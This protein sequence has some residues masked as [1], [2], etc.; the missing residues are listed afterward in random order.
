[1]R[2]RLN[3]G[4]KK[5]KRA[6]PK[7]AINEKAASKSYAIA[8]KIRKPKK[9][10]KTKKGWKPKRNWKPRK[11]K[12]PKDTG[13]SVPFYESSEW[14]ELRYEALKLHGRRCLCCG[15]KAPDVVIHVDHIKPRSI[16]PDLE[17][18]I[19]NLQT[20]CEDCNLGKSN[21]DS[22]DYRINK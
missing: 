21:H 16:R 18:D 22:I 7:L 15:Q 8:D 3:N 9:Q 14:R 17:L 1:M 20:L 5:I 12:K 2:R 10:G 11:T 4:D 13:K 6:M 19:N